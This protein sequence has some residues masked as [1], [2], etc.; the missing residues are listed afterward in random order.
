MMKDKKNYFSDRHEDPN[1]KE[2]RKKFIK[3]YFE[4]EKRTYRW[5]QIREDTAKMFEEDKDEPLL[6]NIFY[7]YKKNNVTMREYHIDTYHKFNNFK[8]SISVRYPD[9]SRPVMHILVRFDFK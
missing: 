4:M 6:R 5:V 1:N 8:P 2:D 9:N 7:E 3:K